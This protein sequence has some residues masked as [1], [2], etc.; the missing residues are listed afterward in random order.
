MRNHSYSSAG[1]YIVNL[2]VTDDDGAV[3]ATSKMIKVHQ[4]LCADV[5]PY[6]D[7]DGKVNMGD[8]VLLLNHVGNPEQFPLEC[9]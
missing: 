9:C 5:A 7:G 3:N 4:L 2:T 1:D 6:P 8:V